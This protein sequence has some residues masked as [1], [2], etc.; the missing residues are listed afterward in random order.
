MRKHFV[1]ASILWVVLTA[2]GEALAFT[3]LLPV[4]GSSEAKDFDWIFRYL[5]ILGIP[6]F[7]FVIAT[8]TY[9]VLRFSRGGKPTEDGPAMHGT[10]KFPKIW[11]AIT[12][13]LTLF[14]MVFPGL[15]GLAK[16]QSDAK[17][18]GWGGETPEMVI[19]VTGQQWYWQVEYPDSNITITGQDK[20]MVLPVNTAIRFEATAKDTIHSL[21][22]PA[23]RM[24]IDA[25]PGRTTYMVV[26][27]TQTGEYASDEAYRF[28]CSQLC[29]L[30]HAKMRMTVRVL[31][32]E[33]F[34]VWVAS[35]QK[36]AQ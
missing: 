27:P 36:P 12:S 16:L 32:K 11:I 4:E 6:V 29:G 20:E 7:T 25:V 2:I 31:S 30:D 24:R 17:G 23:F 21:W 9:S 1:T 33:D 19:R 8:L 15:T 14:V 34:A 5:L 3:N 26:K 28:Q 13:A 18:Y 22:I 10:G 35:Q